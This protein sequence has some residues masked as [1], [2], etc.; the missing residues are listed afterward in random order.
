MSRSS[1]LLVANPKGERVKA[2]FKII[3]DTKQEVIAGVNKIKRLVLLK[4]FV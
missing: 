1:S 4:K 2:D 3:L